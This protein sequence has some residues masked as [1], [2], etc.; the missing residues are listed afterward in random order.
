[1]L[2]PLPLAAQEPQQTHT[3][4][5]GD[6]LWDLAALYLG[7]PFRWP[8]IYR[9][10]TATVQDP[11]LIYPEQVLIIAG[12]VAPTPGTPA[13]PAMADSMAVRDTLAAD[14]LAADS[15]AAQQPVYVQKPM[16]IFNP[17]RFKVVRGERQSL[18]LRSRTEAVRAGDYLQAPFL[19]D[20]DGV[21]N[22]GSIAAT[23]SS[24][25][26]GMTLSKRSIQPY[27]RIYVNVPEGA[28][29]ERDERF[30]SFRYGPTLA[31]EGRV[32]IPTGI[33]KLLGPAADGRAE[34]RV[35]TKFEDVF[36]G[37][38]L[39]PI[40]TLAPRPGD[41]PTRVEFG[42]RTKLLWMYQD[43]VLPTIGHQMI[44]AAGEADG[45]VPGD[46]ITVQRDMGVDSRGVPLPP[47]DI[48]VAQ[49]TRVTEAGTSAIIIAVS[50]GGLLEG[51]AAR[52][53]AKMP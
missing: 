22:P 13:D 51:Q 4:R 19:A 24:D 42:L 15:L 26:V 45:L 41:F 23:I 27:D 43:P 40:D 20:M 1:M 35:L 38:L 5:P 8:E 7:D 12:D 36:E 2:A 47:E 39:M 3:V 49:V 18:V 14:S 46:Q 32:V 11:N 21:D 25:A 52:V 17:D 29:G 31:G 44:F 16:T 6:T 48:A 30:M 34:A 28:A 53:T 50:D 33:I 10:N 37:Q 9:R